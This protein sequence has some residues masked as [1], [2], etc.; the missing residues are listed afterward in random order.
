MRIL[1]VNS[2]SSTIKFSIF[3]S[4]SVESLLEPRCLFDGEVSGIGGS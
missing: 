2:G 1:V 4:G 3:D